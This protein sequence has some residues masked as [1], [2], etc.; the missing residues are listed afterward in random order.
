MISLFLANHVEC[1]YYHYS[2]GHNEQTTPQVRLSTYFSPCRYGEDKV[3][4]TERPALQPS[5]A[6]PI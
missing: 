1:N 3:N 4:A 6:S 2:L 5:P